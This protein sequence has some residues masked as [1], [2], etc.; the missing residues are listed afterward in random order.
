[1]N[2]NT[3]IQ[4]AVGWSIVLSVLMIVVG[5]LAIIVPP[6]SGI[7]VT[8]LVGW[9]MVFNG[10]SHIAF[11]WHTHRAGG[12]FWEILPGVLYIVAGG[13]VLLHPMAGLE[14]LTL[15]LAAYLLLESI[16]ELILSFCHSSSAPYAGRVGCWWMGL[17]PSFSQ[18]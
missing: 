3:E 10:G 2:L 7:A 13:Y 9:L 14:S 5:V 12:L 18:S 16:L 17:S 6:A 11:A 15:V 8:I 4:R 1:M